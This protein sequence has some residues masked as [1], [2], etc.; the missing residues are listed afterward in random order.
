VEGHD[1]IHVAVTGAPALQL[2]HL[3]EFES[4]Y[5]EL[6]CQAFEKCALLRVARSPAHKGQIRGI[7]TEFVQ[8]F[9]RSAMVSARPRPTSLC[10]T[11]CRSTAEHARGSS[12]PIV[13]PTFVKAEMCERAPASFA[14][15]VC[16]Y[17]INASVRTR[18]Y[19]QHGPAALP[20]GPQ[21][22][23][24]DSTRSTDGQSSTSRDQNSGGQREH[25]IGCQV[26]LHC[27]SLH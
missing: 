24:M 12:L 14:E 13:R 15:R 26:P 22:W 8:S 16:G 1:F 4:L 11:G 6:I 19:E 10:V 23:F 20:I 17:P 5:G 7:R 2:H 25:S 21:H 3:L 27:A 18:G 9:V